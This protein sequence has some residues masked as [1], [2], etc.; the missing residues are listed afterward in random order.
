MSSVARAGTDVLRDNENQ[1]LSPNRP[2]V[3]KLTNS[4]KSLKQ[5]VDRTLA[6]LVSYRTKEEK[7]GQAFESVGQMEQAL[8]VIRL[9]DS[10]LK[11]DP[12][13][14]KFKGFKKQ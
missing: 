5:H 2:R 4:I 11:R 8:K 10:Q 7:L 1:H 14:S 9:R 3:D 6:L 12:D 13:M